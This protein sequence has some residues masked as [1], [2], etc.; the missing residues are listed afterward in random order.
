MHEKLGP[1]RL[2]RLLGEGGMGQVYEATAPSGEHV[3]V[4]VLRG[5]AA[6]GERERELFFR[7]ARAGLEFEHPGIVRVLELGEHEGR[8][9]YL[10]MDLLPGPTLKELAGSGPLNLGTVAGLALPVLDALAFLHRNGVLHRDVKTGNIMLD[11]MGRPKLMDFGLTRFSDETSLTQTGLI[12]GSPHYMSPEQGM[13]EELDTRSDVFSM[14]VVIYELLAGRLPFRGDHPIGVVYAIINEEPPPLRRFRPELPEALDWILSRAL[15]KDRHNRYNLASEMAEDIAALLAFQSGAKSELD[16]HAGPQIRDLRGGLPLLGRNDELALLKGWMNRPGGKFL[17][18]AGEAGIGKTRLVREGHRSLG[19][20]AP[21]ML[22]GRTQPGREAFPYQPWLEA[23]RPALREQEI[24]DRAELA[25]FLGAEDAASG[26]AAAILHAFFEGQAAEAPSREQLFEALRRF[27]AA[28]ASREPI[29]LWLED[30]HRADHASLD[31]LSFLARGPVGELPAILVSFREEEVEDDSPLAELRA[32]LEGE[33]RGESLKLARLDEESVAMLV[34]AGLPDLTG[35]E[36]AAERLFRESRGNPFILS[37]LLEN[38]RSRPELFSGESHAEDWDLPLPERLQDLVALR[39]SALDEDERELLDLAA[40]EGE[41]FTA[42]V[43]AAVLGDRK[44]RV[45]RRLQVLQRKTRLIQAAERRFLFDHALVHRVLYESLGEEL[46]EEYHLMVAEHLAGSVSGQPDMAAAV[47]RHFTGAGQRRRALPFLLEAGRHARRLYAHH[48]AHRHLDAAREEA[49]LW[50]LEDP[51]SE[52]AA[53]RRDILRELGE[54]AA[55]EGDYDHSQKLLSGARELLTPGIDDDMRT[56]L[57]RLRGE[58]L[59]FAGRNDEAAAEFEIALA[60]ASEG[61]RRQRALVLRSRARL[62]LR[63]NRW[64]DALKSCDEARLLAE[65][66]PGEALAIRHTMG[67]IQ[68]RRGELAAAREIF[69]EVNDEAPRLEDDSL[70]AA[71]LANLGIVLWR[72]GNHEEAM[73]RLE[74]SLSLRRKTGYLTEIAKVLTNLSIAKTQRGELDEARQFLTEAQGMKQRI[75]EAEGLAHGENSLGNLENRAGRLPT[76]LEHY[77][78]AADLHFEAGNRAGAAVALHNMGEVML[79]MNLLAEAEE[80]LLRSK[81][82]REELDL[83]EGQLSSLRAQARRAALLKEPDRARELFTSARSR[84]D[85]SVGEK[86]KLELNYL[87]F[88]LVSGDLRNARTDLDALIDSA[89]RW[90]PESLA[91]EFTLLEA[92]L[93]SREEKSE[94]ARGIFTRLLDEMSPE[95][96]PYLR[97]R[98]LI[99]ALECELCSS[100]DETEI[101]RQELRTLCDLH[102]FYWLS[103]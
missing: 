85:A 98:T 60:T 65:A 12:F 11:G 58:S 79:D 93:L 64:D 94:E 42:E 44:L 72:L 16:L 75:G 39:L 48:E 22:V 24:W 18:L 45:L 103:S 3:A 8:I 17:F 29:L 78:R 83:R 59:Y 13:G 50:W 62:E 77:R 97:V 41:A 82:L 102:D 38:L 66:F 40:V 2:I 87:Q 10:V 68:L 86:L 4:K 84:E 28:L 96:E 14:G 47:A 80:P 23:L 91:F 34:E 43:L 35:R 70:H 88:L 19:P 100:T 25:I 31:L 95:K 69:D 6:A 27:L 9:P 37:E 26:G 54:L 92:Q 71:S 52:A 30:F 21:L 32:Q 55:T 20:S 89:D 101:L 56:E 81:A 51:V 61:D 67:L 15:A 74:E 57:C 76:A 46:R 73:E 53:L 99:K 49:D 90:P 33:I 1:Y 7:E 63:E 5:G 36:G